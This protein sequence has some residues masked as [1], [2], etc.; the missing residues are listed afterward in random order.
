MRRPRRTRYLATVTPKRGGA[1][2]QMHLLDYSESGAIALAAEHGYT[3]L[4]IA[5][6]REALK[7][8]A[9][10]RT[11]DLDVRAIHAGFEA[12]SGRAIPTHMHL[13]VKTLTTRQGGFVVYP[14]GRLELTVGGELS[15][16][17]ASEAAWHELCHLGQYLRYIEGRN[18]TPGTPEAFKAWRARQKAER[19]MRYGYEN[20]PVE[21]EARTWETLADTDPLVKQEV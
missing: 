18:L 21:R 2:E 8:A 20:R 15:A 14:D 17:R 6:A 19:A 10:K 12:M 11:W 7:R 4:S 3:V 1:A 13:G 9:A 5:P 16:Q